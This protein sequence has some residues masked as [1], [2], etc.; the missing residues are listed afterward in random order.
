ME[1][2]GNGWD[3]NECGLVYGT[4][5]Y[6]WRDL[7]VCMIDGLGCDV[8]ELYMYFQQCDMN[9]LRRLTEFQAQLAFV[10][11]LLILIFI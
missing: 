4:S 3:G 11:L 1:W 10:A 5:V 9:L 2:D 6:V 8:M 7:Y